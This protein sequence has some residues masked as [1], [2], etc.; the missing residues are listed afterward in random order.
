[1]DTDILIYRDKPV[2]DEGEQQC[3]K[4]ITEVREYF[5]EQVSSLK[6]SKKKPRPRA[7]VNSSKGSEKK[8]AKPK[9]TGIRDLLA[10]MAYIY[11]RARGTGRRIWRHNDKVTGKK[12][13]VSKFIDF[14]VA[15][16]GRAGV[17]IPSHQ[18]LCSV[19]E[20]YPRERRLEKKRYRRERKVKAV[21][22]VH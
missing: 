14:V 11:K 3:R 18:A 17:E 20:E 13:R 4:R 15:V 16:C 2:P 6:G 12:I 1:M 19:W 5:D 7:K 9:D 21:V 8:H 10:Q 22:E